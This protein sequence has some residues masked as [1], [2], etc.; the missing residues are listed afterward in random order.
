MIGLLLRVVAVILF[1]AGASN[2]VWLNQPELDLYGWGLAAWCLS[3]IIGGYG[4]PPGPWYKNQ[5]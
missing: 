3:T 4:P 2:Q 5:T 1:I